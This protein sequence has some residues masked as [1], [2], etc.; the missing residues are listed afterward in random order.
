MTINLDTLQLAKG[1]H[2]S[3][4]AG[5]CLLEA[6]AYFAGERHS[7]SPLCVSPVL[8]DFG[9]SIN[10]RL[11]YNQRQEL[12]R[13]IPRLPGTAFDGRDDRRPW[14]ALD[15]LARTCM[16]T[17]LDFVGLT[18][19]ASTLRALPEVV[20]SAT[21]EILAPPLRAVREEVRTTW[22][23]TLNSA[24][25]LDVKWDTSERVA[26]ATTLDLSLEIAQLIDGAANGVVDCSPPTWWLGVV[27]RGIQTPVGA[28][29]LDRLQ[30]SAIDLYDRM[31]DAA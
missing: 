4:D 29:T 5:M 15:W 20:D 27:I 22:C 30:R 25:I 7:D 24:P 13:F 19:H 8:A 12:K 21:A 23:A 17:W 6:V 10:D 2:D 18:E 28:P 1:V 26:M 14:L 16:P 31:I 3:P 9:R 11:P